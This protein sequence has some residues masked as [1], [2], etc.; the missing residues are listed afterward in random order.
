ML[1]KRITKLPP[2]C[3]ET[4]KTGKINKTSIVHCSMLVPWCTAVYIGH[5]W[6]EHSATHSNGE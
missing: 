3:Y 2:A 4:T 6:H 1:I 5:G